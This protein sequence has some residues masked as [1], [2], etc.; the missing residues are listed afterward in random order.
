MNFAWAKYRYQKEME[1]KW[2]HYLG[3]GRVP[4]ISIL[5]VLVLQI[6]RSNNVKTNQHKFAT[7]HKKN[8]HLLYLHLPSVFF[9]EVKK[10][11]NL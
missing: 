10:I 7:G 1:D 3:D 4:D 11:A 5:N 8:S 2:K 9:F 6:K